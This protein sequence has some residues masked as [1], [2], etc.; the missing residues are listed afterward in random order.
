MQ[1]HILM[2]KALQEFKKLDKLPNNKY[3]FFASSIANDFSNG[4]QRGYYC[5]EV[6]I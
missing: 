5:Q 4:G 1:I 6:N 2:K 3:S